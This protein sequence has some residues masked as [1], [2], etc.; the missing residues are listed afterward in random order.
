AAAV[1]QICAR[2]DGLPL[3]IELAAAR[4]KLFSPSALLSQLTSSLDLA[5]GQRHVSER[6]LTIRNA[7]DWSYRLLAPEEQKLF[8][9]LGV[10][11]GDFG[12]REVEGVAGGEEPRLLDRLS[13]LAEKSMIRQ[14]E[15]AGERRFRLLD[16]LREYATEQLAQAGES[17]RYRAAHLDYFRALAR[18]LG[19]GMMSIAND[20]SKSGLMAANDDLRA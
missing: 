9:A 17:E 8:R 1:G 2:L 20:S 12:L 3:A 10:F 14:F 11:A 16:V 4:S 19:P 6:Q 15:Y 7:I 5:S 13:G 18:D